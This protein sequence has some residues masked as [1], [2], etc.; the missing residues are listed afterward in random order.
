MRYKFALALPVAAA[1]FVSAPFAA[2]PALAQPTTITACQ[3]ISK[4]GSYQLA[5]NLSGPGPGPAGTCLFITASFLTIDLQGFTISGPLSGAG[6]TASQGVDFITVRNGFISGFI[7]AVGL[8]G[9]ASVVEGLTVSGPWRESGRLTRRRDTPTAGIGAQG[10]VKNHIVVGETHNGISGGGTVTGNYVF[11]NGRG[12]PPG[13]GMEVSAGSTVI[14]NTVDSNFIG[15][16]VDCPS[17]VT[18]NTATGND[19]HNLVLN[20]KGCKSSNNVAP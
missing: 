3:T 10:I 9:V 17:N 2:R 5:A 19:L 15:L 14:G 4:P 18:D 6:I 12:T 7:G 8:P 16:V 20:G 13:P 11:S 1:L